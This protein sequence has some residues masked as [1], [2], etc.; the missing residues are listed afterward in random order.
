MMEMLQ[1]QVLSIIKKP[2]AY[3]LTDLKPTGEYNVDIYLKRADMPLDMP[4]NSF[5][6]DKSSLC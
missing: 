2:T 3:I 1:Y 6:I 5:N 4:I